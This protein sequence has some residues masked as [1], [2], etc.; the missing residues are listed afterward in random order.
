LK[1][2]TPAK[3]KNAH[4][5]SMGHSL[6]FLPVQFQSIRSP[7]LVGRGR[8]AIGRRK[9]LS[10]KAENAAAT[11]GT[12]PPSRRVHLHP[13][14]AI[15]GISAKSGWSLGSL[16]LHVGPRWTSICVLDEMRHQPEELAMENRT[17]ATVD[18]HGQRPQQHQGNQGQQ[19]HKHDRP[20]VQQPGQQ[21]QKQQ[22]QQP[23]PVEQPKAASEYLSHGDW[24]IHRKTFEKVVT[25]IH[26]I[27]A[28]VVIFGALLMLVCLTRAGLLI[29]SGAST[30]GDVVVAILL[31]IGC[32]GI[33]K[34]TA[35]LHWRLSRLVI[36]RA[37][38]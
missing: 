34:A 31:I 21:Q 15:G 28:S 5:A 17:L 13:V 36:R 29:T 16:N 18:N 20:N 6:V 2:L 11:G 24:M 3:V 22:Q 10:D 23:K 4:P 27:V 12:T 32:M 9:G 30:G 33:G 19:H 25:T 7:I 14:P 26:V 37:G 35:E 1:P 38:K 8:A